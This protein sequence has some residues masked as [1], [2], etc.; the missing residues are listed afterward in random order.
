MT[1]RTAATPPEGPYSSRAEALSQARF[2]LGIAGIAC[3]AAAVA[4]DQRLL[5][6]IAIALLAVSVV[7]RL[8]ARRRAGDRT[9]GEADGPE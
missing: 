6:W 7:L 8:V 4:S 2:W 1:R 5:G 3:A 9:P